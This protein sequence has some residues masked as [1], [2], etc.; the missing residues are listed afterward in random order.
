MVDIDDDAPGARTWTTWTTDEERVKAVA[1][2][3]QSPRSARG[4]AE[5]ALV[6][7][8]RTRGILSN[9]VDEGV[10]CEVERNDVVRYGPDREHIR[11][12]GIRMLHEADDPGELQERREYLVERLHDCEEPAHIMLLEHSLEV[13]EAALDTSRNETLDDQS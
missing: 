9:L 10:V 1:V 5:E 7:A 12:E 4:I 8:E 2:S 11:R 3:D 13:V 6:G